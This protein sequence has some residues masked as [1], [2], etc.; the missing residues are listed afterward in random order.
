MYLTDVFRRVRDL[1]RTTRQSVAKWAQ[2][3]HPGNAGSVRLQV[4]PPLQM[5]AFT[6]DSQTSYQFAM[7]LCRLA[8][9]VKRQ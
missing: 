6:G 5:L 7:E 1:D 2:N 3:F 4:R 8:S 9:A